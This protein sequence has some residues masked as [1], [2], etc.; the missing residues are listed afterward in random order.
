MAELLCLNYYDGTTMTKLIAKEYKYECTTMAVLLCFNYYNMTDSQG[1]RKSLNYYGS[2][3][4]LEVTGG[5][6]I[7]DSVFYLFR[8]ISGAMVALPCQPQPR[9]TSRRLCP[10]LC[11]RVSHLKGKQGE[12]VYLQAAQPYLAGDLRSGTFCLPSFRRGH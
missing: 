9:S 3:T 12:A 7:L 11:P 8:S 4:M 5:L 2:T 6:H 10:S 1:M